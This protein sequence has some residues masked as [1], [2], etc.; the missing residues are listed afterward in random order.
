[1]VVLV[2]G[3]V[4]ALW[5]RPPAPSASAT[6]GRLVRYVVSEP[7][8]PAFAWEVAE[9]A[10]PALDRVAAEWGVDPRAY[11]LLVAREGWLIHESYFHG[12]DAETPANLK[13]IGK[14]WI[15]TLVGVALQRGDLDTVEREV[16]ELIPAHYADLPVDDVRRRVTVEQLMTMRS[17]YR[18]PDER[19]GALFRQ[20][21]WVRA[22]VHD[23]LVHAPGKQFFYSTAQTHLV[24]GALA[25]VVEESLFEF[26]E[27][28]LCAPLGISVRRWHR[29]PAGAWFGGS[30]LWLVPRDLLRLG[31]LYLQDGV[32][33]GQRILPAGWAEDSW[34]DRRGGDARVPGFGY[35]WWLRR[36]AD[37]QPVRMAYGQGGQVLATYPDSGHMVVLTC[38][39]ESKAMPAAEVEQLLL[40]QLPAVGL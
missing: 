21:D 8:R 5:L 4:G 37:G 15:T 35:S 11:S 26:A 34:R 14:L 17:G 40:V 3:V 27:K 33:D 28:E 2:L 9:G 16:A 19:L 18:T 10:N 30:E 6:R 36:T 22:V 38:G 23:R 12:R 13:S 24:A 39:V 29:D 31:Q 7:P 20:D 1:M 32:V 25:G